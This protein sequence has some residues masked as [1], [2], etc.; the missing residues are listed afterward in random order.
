MVK[1]I[2]NLF[3]RNSLHNKMPYFR[4]SGL[5]VAKSLIEETEAHIVI[6]LIFI[7]LLFLLGFCKVKN[8][9]VLVTWPRDCLLYERHF[10]LQNIVYHQDISVERW[11]KINHH[12]KLVIIIIL[13]H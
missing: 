13:S 9:R 3:H 7:L 5:D 2:Q 1:I 12:V 11:Y 10:L 6:R 4:M 8:K